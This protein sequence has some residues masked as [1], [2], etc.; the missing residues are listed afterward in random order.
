[1]GVFYAIELASYHGLHFA[2]LNI[3]P[4]SDRRFHVIV[5]A[6]AVAWSLIALVTLFCLR[7]RIFSAALKYLTTGADVA[8]LTLVV[9][10]GD[11]PRSAMLVG[12]FLIIAL[13]TLR[14]RL[15]L[16]W[17]ASGFSLLGYLIV[18]GCCKWFPQPERDLTVPRYEQLIMIAALVLE[19]VIL[20]QVVRQV[21]RVAADY[22]RRLARAR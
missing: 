10:A 15:G 13:A 16:V 19:G 1:M 12:Y 7:A 22:A 6:L 14:F 5:T 2:G 17:Y 4:T 20:G 11:G 9:V 3:D 8:L 18:L 21:R